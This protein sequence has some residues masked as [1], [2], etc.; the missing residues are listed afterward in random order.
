M[1]LCLF[2]DD[3]VSHLLPLVYTR[4]VYDL[5]IGIR[6]LLRTQLNAFDAK[7]ALLHARK[8][9]AEATGAENAL[10]VNR[11][12]E[13][14]DVL[15]LNG[16]YVPEEGPLLDTL[17]EIARGGASGRVFVQEGELVAAWVP[18]AS[19]RL[20]S[21]D[22]VTRATFAEL[23]EEE[24][25]GALMMRRVWDL[26]N[27]IRPAIERDF[28]FLV[29]GY[30]VFERPDVK[31][32]QGA[33]LVGGE[34]IFLGKGADIR[35]G[36]ILN[37]DDGPIYIDED[38]VVQENAVL[39]GPAYV[40][41]QSQIKVSADIEGSAFGTRCKVG[42]EVHDSVLQSHSNKAHAGFLGHSYFGRW[43]NVGADTNNSDLKNNYGSVSLYD[44]AT[45]QFEDT[46]CMF[47]GLIMG[48]HSKCGID[49]MFNTGTV[50]GISC[51]VYGAG[52]QPRFIPSFSWGGPSEM[53]E[54][55]LDK[56]L[57]VAETVMGRRNIALT[58]AEREMLTGVFEAT[59]NE[60]AQHHS[61][62]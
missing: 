28:D 54:Y 29:K 21:E 19:S 38:A 48:D 62:L 53:T 12:P 58:A 45:G 33:L 10:L 7:Q 1:Y 22:A 14:L 17:R 27:G 56:A 61:R 46:G 5:R 51:N 37:A 40:G 57:Q 50:V 41:P 39:R 11:I 15:F 35:P 59:R 31:I 52:F 18:Q 20:V 16:R 42:G 36:A 26:I 25:E 43:C 55:R 24:V 8:A 32:G 44:P 23:P 47:L 49:T 3:Q 60:R 30:N 9:V 2:E 34:R 4:G 13:G 6:T